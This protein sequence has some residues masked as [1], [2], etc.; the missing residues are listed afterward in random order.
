MN[1]IEHWNALV[2]AEYRKRLLDALLKNDKVKIGPIVTA[3]I[4]SIEPATVKRIA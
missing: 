3:A 2:K 4:N 1:A